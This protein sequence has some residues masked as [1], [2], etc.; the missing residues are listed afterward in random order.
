MASLKEALNDPSKKPS[1]VRDC[2]Q[3]IDDE[4]KDK[5]GVSGFAIKAGY[6]A[7]K[8]IK[9]GFLDGVVEW[10]LPEFAEGLDPIHQEAVSQGRPVR[11]HFMDEKGRVADA[12]L[13]ITDEKA[14]STKNGL[15]RGTYKKLRGTAK[16]NV[17]AAVPRLAGL[18]ETYANA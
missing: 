5:G 9:P 7:V 4:V 18:I 8:G 10:L 3:L 12:L 17:E 13:K 1:I 2:L 16:K 14:A 6:K 15:I 11:D